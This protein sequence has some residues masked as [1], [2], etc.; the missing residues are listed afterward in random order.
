MAEHH[1]LYAEISKIKGLKF[2]LIKQ[3][4]ENWLSKE[5][6]HLFKDNGDG[7]EWSN[8]RDY[9]S[10]LYLYETDEVIVSDKNG[11]KKIK[12]QIVV[13][14]VD[15]NAD[16]PYTFSEDEIQ[17]IKSGFDP[18]GEKYREIYLSTY[19][20]FVNHSLFKIK[21]SDINYIACHGHKCRRTVGISDGIW[22]ESCNGEFEMCDLKYLMY[23]KISLNDIPKDSLVSIHLLNDMIDDI[24][25]IGDINEL[26]KVYDLLFNQQKVAIDLQ[27]EIDNVENNIQEYAE[28]M[29][30]E[31]IDKEKELQNNLS[32]FDGGKNTLDSLTKSFGEKIQNIKDADA[33]REREIQEKRDR[34]EQQL[35]EIE[36]QKAA[37][38]EERIK[39]MDQM[40]S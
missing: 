22:C 9:N 18:D 20:M 37:L 8:Y 17:M 10:F 28:K 40:S 19:D 32:V 27:Q 6:L 14:I 35:S 7:I 11:L 30:R 36:Q 5:N 13:N 12:Y 3:I 2:N 26:Q 15:K 16:F 23:D 21:F 1:P 25:D 4:D 31:K 24:D 38:E 34:I 39:L 29:R 33:A